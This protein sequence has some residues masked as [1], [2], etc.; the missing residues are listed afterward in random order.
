MLAYSLGQFL[1]EDQWMMDICHLTQHL[2]LHYL[3]KIEQ[4]KHCILYSMQYYFFIEIMHKN[5][6]FYM[7]VTLANSLFNCPVV[8]LPRANV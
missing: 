8:Q 5:H 1:T 7:L 4:T 6:I 3:G 2:F